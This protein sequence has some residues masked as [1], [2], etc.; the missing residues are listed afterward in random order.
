MKTL[1]ANAIAALE[2]GEVVIAG[3]ARFSF[4][5]TYRLWSGVGDRTFD[6]QT[7]TGVDAPVLIVPI[8][9]ETGSG[10]DGVTIALSALDSRIAATIDAEDYHQKPVTLWRWIFSADGLTL[11][12]GHRF[13]VGRCDVVTIRE[14]TPGSSELVF[15]IEG[16]GRDLDRRSARVRSN[17]D[18][19]LLGGA[20]D[21]SMKHISTAGV[22]SLYWGRS[23]PSSAP[24]N[25][26]GGGSP[27]G[28]GGLHFNLQ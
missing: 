22:R 7:F 16:A 25:S 10:T 5:T 26:Y 28:P 20:S 8:Q 12:D 19:R 23:T 18:Q 21:G 13:F 6:G 27:F 2:S 11:L 17:T 15:A 24:G 1:N 4:G 9:S 3:A 14:T